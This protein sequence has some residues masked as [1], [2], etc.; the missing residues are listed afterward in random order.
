MAQERAKP[1]PA[2]VAETLVQ[3]HTVETADLRARLTAPE[4][5]M[6]LFL[7]CELKQP[8]SA[9]SFSRVTLLG[10]LPQGVPAKLLHV[11]VLDDIAERLNGGESVVGRRIAK[12]TE[13]TPSRDGKLVL[14]VKTYNRKENTPE[15]VDP[16]FMKQFDNV[17][18]DMVVGRVYPPHPGAPG[19]TVLGTD[20]PG[21]PGNAIAV[22][23]AESI[24]L[25]PA[26]DKSY[27]NLVAQTSGY[28]RIEKGKLEVVH[29]LVL[30]GNVDPHTGDINFVGN[31]VVK[32]NVNKD[33]RVS[34][35][36]NIDIQGNVQDG[37][38]SSAEGN[39]SV[40]GHVS[41][42]MGENVLVSEN[43]PFQQLLR[44]AGHK[45]RQITCAGVF[46][47]ALVDRIALEA[48]CDIEIEKEARASY[49]RTRATLK[50]PNGQ[51]IGGQ[52]YTVCGAEAKI[53]GTHLGTITQI[54][55]C[56]DI[57]SS[58]EYGALIEKVRAHD[59]AEEMIRLYLGP[60]ADNPARIQLLLPA[61]KAK[62]EK[63]KKKL[64]KIAEG[65]K[66]LLEE[67]ANLMR[68]ARHNIVHRVNVLKVAHPGVCIHA[69][70]DIFKV[71][72]DL[73]G[74]KTIEYFPKEKRFAVG[75][76]QALQCVLEKG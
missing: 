32:G 16:W 61:L 74:P 28:L 45:R 3:V 29:D 42:E 53:I 7:D 30:G 52:V 11:E 57:E 43:I 44:V 63:L 10:L 12:G 22:E 50:M 27:S 23:L 54:F 67:Q 33:F 46:R 36:G 8:R 73:V 34:A 59:S 26:E 48:L 14:L 71:E 70:E 40:K 2:P 69:G 5:R 72:E 47:A 24:V 6:K 1:N 21:P 51:L 58:A 15:L 76:L 13:P 37:I 18:K 60:Y 66:V 65:R 39:I 20:I 62:M 4:S 9:H 41:G 56:S 64:D 38:L 17:E 25:Q 75:D 35:R 55:L 49:L 19:M 68:N 31:I